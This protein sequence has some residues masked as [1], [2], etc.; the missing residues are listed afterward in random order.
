MEEDLKNFIQIF[1]NN[2]K[3]L[4]RKNK[5][6]IM[7][8]IIPIIFLFV[9]IK[10]VI[11]QSDL[12]NKEFYIMEYIPGDCTDSGWWIIGNKDNP[13]ISPYIYVYLEGK[14]P[15]RYLSNSICYAYNKY[16]IYGS[17]EKETRISNIGCEYDCYVLKG[18][19]W[20]ILEEVKG[21]IHKR[22]ITIYD[23]KWFK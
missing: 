2:F 16:I 15:S 8:I 18:K 13:S 3:N 11:K 9:P 10:F 19:G 17:L 21:G 4:K 23:L 1:I 20:D 6:I 5:I 14:K 22:F 12:C 7:M